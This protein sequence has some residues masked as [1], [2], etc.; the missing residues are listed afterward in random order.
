MNELLDTRP[1]QWMLQDSDAPWRVIGAMVERGTDEEKFAWTLIRGTNAELS[2]WIEY[3]QQGRD[4]PERPIPSP[5]VEIRTGAR[6]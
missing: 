6:T 5:D 4:D 3:L 1:H 2:L